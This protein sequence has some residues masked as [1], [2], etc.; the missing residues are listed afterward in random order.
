TLYTY[1][2]FARPVRMV[3]NTA[4]GMPVISDGGRTYTLKVRPGIYF[5]DDPAFKGK[6]RELVAADYVFSVKRIF[7]PKV[8]SYWVYLFE[9][10]LV[11]LDEVL[12]DARKNGRLDYERKIEGLQLI[13]RYTFRVR[14]K[15]P[16]YIFREW[17]T[18]DAFAAVAP[19]VVAAY[20]DESNR[21]MDHPVGTGPYRLKEWVRGQKI[22]LEANPDFR[23]EKYPAP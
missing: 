1:D 20:Q 14:F 15:E 16:N 11:G 10:Q 2:Y 5:A 8:R 22:V 17:L 7:D 12:A 3:P 4:D 9:K 21:V 23:D 18:F 13:D 6:K 19:E